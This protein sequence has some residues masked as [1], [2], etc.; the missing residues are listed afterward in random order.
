MRSRVKWIP[1][2]TVA[3]FAGCGGHNPPVTVVGAAADLR[4]L[5]GAW[6]G[7]YSSPLTGRTGSIVFELQSNPDSAFGR[8]V[9]TPHGAAG[10]IEPWRNPRGPLPAPTELTIRFV[11]VANGRVS[12]SLTPYADPATGEP[13]FTVF[14]GRVTGDTIEGTYTTRPG[15]NEPTGRWQVVRDRR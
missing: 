7:D 14:E 12:G 6:F 10:P 13:L 3:A 1:L 15:S 8:V 2:L 4:T 9:M 11:R 5:T